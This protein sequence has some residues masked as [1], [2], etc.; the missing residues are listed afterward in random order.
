MTI[1]QRMERLERQ[2]GRL[3][4]GMIGMVIAS[5]SLL[6]MGQA[7]PPKVHDVVKAKKFV[8]V[9]ENGRAMVSIG[10][11][12]FFGTV[13]VWAKEKIVASMSANDKL[14]GLLR[15][16]NARGKKLVS[17]SGLKNGGG[18]ISTFNANGRKLVIIG[19]TKGGAGTVSTNDLAGRRLIAITSDKGGRGKVGQYNRSGKVNALWPPASRRRR[20]R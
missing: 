9:G 17:I 8:A 20:T 12:R 15:T 11:T 1:E 7:L 2:Y 19:S 18:T 16:Q 10:S 4:R 6:V 5:L 3:K 14:G 13:Y